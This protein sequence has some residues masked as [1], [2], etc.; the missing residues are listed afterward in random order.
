L[1]DCQEKRNLTPFFL[2]DLQRHLFAGMPRGRRH[3]GAKETKGFAQRSPIVPVQTIH[4]ASSL[5]RWGNRSGCFV[6]VR[7]TVM[8]SRSGVLMH[9]HHAQRVKGKSQA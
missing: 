5:E 2:H 9:L 3:G 1:L 7:K 8:I 6:E 4:G